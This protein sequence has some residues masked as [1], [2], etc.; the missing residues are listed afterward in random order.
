MLVTTTNGL[1]TT[2]V[3]EKFGVKKFSSLVWHDESWTH[4]IFLTLNK[5]QCLLFIGDSKGR[6]YF[7]TNKFHMKISNGEFFPN[8]SISKYQL[9]YICM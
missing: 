5:K 1:C 6:K 7:T 3:W 2:V 9:T 4:E 8:Y